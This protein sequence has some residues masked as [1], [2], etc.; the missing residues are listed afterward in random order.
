M[1]KFSFTSQPKLR[2]LSDLQIE[3][4]HDCALRVLKNVGVRFHCDEALKILG[5][6]DCDVDLKNKIV[7]FNNTKVMDSIR[8]APET[9]KHYY[10][11][12]DR[13]LEIGGNNIFYYPG[14]TAVNF[15]E[16]DGKTVRSPKCQDFIHYSQIV[17]RLDFVDVQTSCMLLTDVPEDFIEIMKVYIALLF[18][19]KPLITSTFKKENTR[20]VVNMIEA[21]SGDKE[22]MKKKSCTAF[23]YCPSPPLTWAEVIV[24]NVIETAKNGLPLIFVSMPQLG[25]TAPAT[26]AG[27][28]VQ[29]TAEILS[30]LVLAQAISPG[31]PV[32]YGGTPLLFDMK[33]ATSALGAIETYMMDIGISQ[34]GRFY[35][36]PVRATM[37]ETDSKC[38]DTQTGWETGMG[39][40]IGTLAE[41]NLISGS[42]MIESARC[43][44]LEKLVMDNEIA[45]MCRRLSN[46]ID[47]D[48]DRLAYNVIAEAGPE[49]SFL[50]NEHT[51]KYFKK[52]QYFPSLLTDR[53]ERAEWERLGASTTLDRAKDR[54]RELLEKSSK[55][56]PYLEGEK[57][58]NLK[59]VFKE[60]CVRR[61]I[62]KLPFIA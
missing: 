22:T 5:D 60:I 10:I 2:I 31:L 19:D 48:E 4:I 59:R 33:T 30:G 43:Q 7:K 45:G 17:Q 37:T 26:I 15:M 28:L 46:G 35:G 13:F 47:V 58:E 25:A 24:E 12:K 29:H 44:S 23:I 36:L 61:N 18:C 54:V 3:E 49:G 39:F 40:L 56:G 32:V 11:N 14:S 53:K 6:H 34:I 27:C 57:L 1:P 62:S 16:S 41:I 52:E 38:L 55:N 50:T 21:V 9:F 51:F 8:S 42:G 20:D